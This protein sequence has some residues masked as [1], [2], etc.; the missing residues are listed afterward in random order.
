MQT[1]PASGECICLRGRNLAGNCHTS[2]TDSTW[3]APGCPPNWPGDGACDSACDVEEC[4]FDLGDCDRSVPTAEECTACIACDPCQAC[5]TDP[6]A[7]APGGDLF[8]RCAVDCA[9][10]APGLEDC[11]VG[12]YAD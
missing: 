12:E 6:W 10:A 3:C 7:C 9:P 2:G 8:Q 4:G 1:V 5:L 11:A